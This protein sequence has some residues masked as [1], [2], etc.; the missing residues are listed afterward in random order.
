[1]RAIPELK[2]AADGNMS[3]ADVSSSSSSGDGGGGSSKR[4][5]KRRESNGCIGSHH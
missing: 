1:L 3:D 2:E 4:R 5:R